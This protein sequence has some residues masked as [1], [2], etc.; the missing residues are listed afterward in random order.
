MTGPTPAD[1]AELVRLPAAL[2]VPG[3]TLA[4]AA[5]AG[6]P[7]GARTALAPAAS[8]SLYLAGMALNDY[9][10]R[11]LDAIERPERP[12]PSGRVSPPTAL[13]VAGG[14]TA[15]GL[16][17]AAGTGRRGAV[18]GAAVAATAWG[19]DTLAKPTR[20][21]PVVMGLARALDVMLGAQGRAS[22]L[23][24][25]A[26]VGAHTVAVTAL[27]RGEVTGTSPRTARAVAATSAV[28]A[29]GSMALGGTSVNSTLGNTSVSSSI[30]GAR[31]RALLAA[32]FALAYLNTVA[33]AQLDAVA[34]PDAAHARAA[35]GSGIRGMLP[36]QA[37]LLA[38]AG[39][40]LPAIGLLAAAPVLR[41]LARL[42][43][44][45]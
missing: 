24:A 20:L 26:L 41:R 7:A 13:C 15:L 17:C 12:I 35:T 25:A 9:A 6:W 27:A 5:A 34:H 43:A 21:G 19:Y 29:A 2:T 36:L 40:A 45:T 1:L 16:V 4:G 30:L 44:T 11:H 10:D 8:I 3:D 18:I 37:S 22:G 32:P 31:G 28:V 14:L 39:A 42:V 33:R 23:P 38:G